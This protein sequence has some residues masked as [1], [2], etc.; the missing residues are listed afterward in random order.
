MNY[1]KHILIGGDVAY[2]NG[3]TAFIEKDFGY[4]GIQVWQSEY[5]DKLMKWTRVKTDLELY[6]KVVNSKPQLEEKK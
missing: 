1:V 5:D 6:K 4:D 3:K 2:V